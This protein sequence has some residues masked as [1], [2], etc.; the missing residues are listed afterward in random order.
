MM[1]RENES[2]TLVGPFVYR[3]D[4]FDYAIE[5]SPAR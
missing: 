5:C 3:F 4:G 1:R 2:G